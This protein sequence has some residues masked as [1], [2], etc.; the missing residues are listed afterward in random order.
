MNESGEATRRRY[1]DELG[2][3]FGAAFYGLWSEWVWGLMR[4]NEF[5]VLFSRSENVDLLNA[6]VGGNLT[7]DIQRIFWDDLLLRICR[8]TDPPKSGG[9][10]NL[11]VTLLPAFCEDAD[12]TLRDDVVRCAQ[13][14]V[15]RA[16][17][18]RAWRNQRISHTDWNRAKRKGKRLPDAT[19]Q[20]MESALDAVHS[21][22]N[23]I[24]VRLINV[25]IANIPAP[26][27]RAAKFLAN[28]RQL[29]DAVKLLDTLVDADGGTDYTDIGV[30]RT[31][32]HKLGHP[33]PAEQIHKVIGLRHAAQRYTAR[34]GAG[35]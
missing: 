8:L 3:E 5:R 26:T 23:T 29:V 16:G 15:D 25:E 18:A 12:G 11:S 13:T 4:L 32:F 27:L 30:A 24:S 19:L 34:M 20:Q 14:A 7:W 21:V 2:E 35:S 9:K 1:Q 28:A 31:F 33:A 6:V 22:L 10:N 17:F